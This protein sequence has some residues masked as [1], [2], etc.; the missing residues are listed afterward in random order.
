MGPHRAAPGS[1]LALARARPVR[2]TLLKGNRASTARLPA[3]IDPHQVVRR[4]EVRLLR[5]PGGARD[6][7]ATAGT[8]GAGRPD[9]G[10][11][12]AEARGARRPPE[13]VR[14]GVFRLPPG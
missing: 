3:A 8:A 13:R 1:V 11:R 14:A 10:F 2:P 5:S 4:K 6:A 12:R 7:R 9:A